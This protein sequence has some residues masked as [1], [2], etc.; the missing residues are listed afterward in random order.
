M[1]KRVLQAA[2]HHVLL[3]L[4]VI[5]EVISLRYYVV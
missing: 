4:S 2:S 5:E 1:E 3:S